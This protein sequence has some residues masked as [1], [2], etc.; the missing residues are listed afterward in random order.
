[1]KNL[2]LTLSLMITFLYNVKGNGPL[3]IQANAS[4]LIGICGDTI[5]LRGINYAA[6]NWGN[7]F[8]D[9]RFSE[10]AMTGA[11]CIRIPW[12]SSSAAGGGAP[13]YDH[14]EYLDS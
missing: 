1:M 6:F 10:I 5:V 3:T 9:D 11:N 2:I 12:Y 7:D 8:T 4:Y 13:L 14:L